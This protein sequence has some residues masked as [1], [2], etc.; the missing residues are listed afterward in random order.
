MHGA[1][2]RNTQPPSVAH[3]DVFDTVMAAFARGA[4][5]R[6]RQPFVA[7][8]GVENT[9]PPGSTSAPRSLP[10]E[11]GAVS[12]LID[13]GGRTFRFSGDPQDIYFRELAQFAKDAPELGWF[14]SARLPRDAICIDVGANIGLT[15]I[16]LASH[17]EQG[18]VYAFEPSPVNCRYLRQNIEANRASQHHGD[19]GCGR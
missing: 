16:T 2:D 4:W 9:P 5:R 12:R 6:I 13:V 14:V 19:R 3:D 17:C 1:P 15:A 7:A 10:P 11:D 18:H 8:S